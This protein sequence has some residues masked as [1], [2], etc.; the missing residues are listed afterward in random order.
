MSEELLPCPFCW[1][2]PQLYGIPSEGNQ[3]Y[4][5]C[6]CLEHTVKR[7][8]WQNA[9]WAKETARLKEELEAQANFWEGR[10]AKLLAEIAT[11]RAAFKARE[12]EF[13]RSEKELSKE[14]QRSA[15]YKSSLAKAVEGL[16]KIANMPGPT[17][18][19]E[20]VWTVTEFSQQR[21]IA[22]ETLAAIRGKEE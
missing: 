11:V 4:A 21:N 15:A 20:R 5:R 3:V 1:K 17:F 19:G 14:K 9:W 22:I 16:E 10:Q 8:V 12:G 6:E 2:F 7:E 13:N 18:N